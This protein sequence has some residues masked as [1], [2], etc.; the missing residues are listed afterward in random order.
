VQSVKLLLSYLFYLSIWVV[1]FWNLL[2]IFSYF[3]HISM[4]CLDW[5]YLIW[6]LMKFTVQKLNLKLIHT[7]RVLSFLFAALRF[8][9]MD[10]CLLGKHSATWA[11]AP[12]FHLLDISKI[13]F[14]EL[15]ARGCLQ[16]HILLISASWVTRITH[17]SH[18]YLTLKVF[19]T[20]NPAWGFEMKCLLGCEVQ[21]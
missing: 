2:C 17:R 9:F 3:Q 18:R 19:Q 16:T 14:F 21:W 20:V 6:D 12:A 5:K 8:E 10:S 15:I 13:G 4:W 7:S 1:S 11:I